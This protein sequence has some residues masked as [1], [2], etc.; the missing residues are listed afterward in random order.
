MQVLDTGPM[1][2]NDSCGNT[3]DHDIVKE[4]IPMHT[5]AWVVKAMI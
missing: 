1:Q 2:C 5:A 3:C 4:L